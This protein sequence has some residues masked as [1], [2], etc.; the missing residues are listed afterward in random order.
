[1]CQYFK[2]SFITKMAQ[3]KKWDFE[4]D[5]AMEKKELL[6]NKMYLYTV[7]GTIEEVFC[8]K[9][10]VIIFIQIILCILINT[11]TLFVYVLFKY[12]QGTPVDQHTLNFHMKLLRLDPSRQVAI[13]QDLIFVQLMIF[14]LMI[15]MAMY[16]EHFK[17]SANL[18]PMVVPETK[19]M[20]LK[21]IE[22]RL[23][24]YLYDPPRLGASLRGQ[25]SQIYID[26][27]RELDK[28]LNLSS[29]TDEEREKLSAG[30]VKSDESSVS[31]GEAE[32]KEKGS[33][34]VSSSSEEV[35]QGIDS[36]EYVMS[37]GTSLEK[38]ILFTYFNKTKLSVAQII[39]SVLFSIPRVT[40]SLMIIN[41]CYSN[42]WIDPFII[43][44][45]FLYSFR[46]TKTF[47]DSSFQ[48]LFFFAVYFLVNWM[49]LRFSV[50]GQILK[51]EGVSDFLELRKTLNT[52]T[53]DGGYPFLCRYVLLL[54][55]AAYCVGFIVLIGWTYYIL[56][57]LFVLKKEDQEN[58]HTS[59]L[60]GYLVIDYKK[61]K[62]TSFGKVNFLIK[63]I[64]SRIQEA[65]AFTI[66]FV[67]IQIQGHDWFKFP[68]IFTVFL[69]VTSQNVQVLSNISDALLNRK[70]ASDARKREFLDLACMIINGLCWVNLVATSVLSRV[71]DF[72]QEDTSMGVIVILYVTA[73]I[74]DI[75]M[76]KDFDKAR[77]IIQLEEKVKSAFVGLN[78]VYSQNEKKLFSRMISFIGKHKL[79][80][81]AKN[82]VMN[83]DFEQVPL[84][85]DYNAPNVEKV[86]EA[87]YAKLLRESFKGTEF[88]KHKIV[89][90]IYTFL[91]GLINHFR[92]QDLFVL[93]RNAIKRN[94]LVLEEKKLNLKRYF[95]NDLSDLQNTLK[96]IKLFYQM[97]RER[98]PFKTQFFKEKLEEFRKAYVDEMDKKIVGKTYTEIVRDAWTKDSELKDSP[99]TMMLRKSESEIQ[100]CV[101]VLLEYLTRKTTDGKKGLVYYDHLKGT[102]R[103]K[104]PVAC[105]YAGLNIVLYDMK[106]DLL[107][108]TEGFFLF[109]PKLIFS[110]LLRTIMSKVEHSAALLIIILSTMNG[111]I[112]NMLNIGIILFLILIEETH[113]RLFWWRMVY[114]IFLLKLLLMSG[115]ES[116]PMKAFCFGTNMGYDVLQLLFVNFVI[117]EQRKLGFGETE[118]LGIEDLGSAVIRIISNKEFIPFYDR[119]TELPKQKLEMLV[120][121]ITKLCEK[122]RSS[123]FFCK[124]KNTC[125]LSVVKLYHELDKF[126]ESGLRIGALLMCRIKDD[127]Y[128]N[129]P[130]TTSQFWYRNFS[131]YTRKVGENL[132]A[133]IFFLLFIILGFVLLFFRFNDRSIEF[134]F[135]AID[136][137]GTKSKNELAYI[138]VYIT[139]IFTEKCFCS[140]STED[141]TGVK[142]SPLY[143]EIMR[144]HCESNPHMKRETSTMSER[145]KTAVKVVQNIMRLVIKGRV[146][147]KMEKNPEVYRY[148]LLILT[149][150]LVNASV[151]IIQPLVRDKQS[152]PV[153]DHAWNSFFCLPPK[154][155]NIA[156]SNACYSY[157][158]MVFSKIFYFLN[159]LYI[160]A[161]IQQ[162]RKGSI[163]KI[164]EV[165]NYKELSSLMSYYL[166]YKPPVLREVCTLIEYSCERTTLELNDWLLCE[167]LK[168][169]AIKA[170]ISHCT[171]ELKD[172]GKMVPRS[173]R[174]ALSTAVLSMLGL[175][176]ILPLLIFSKFSTG[177]STQGIVE[178]S[179]TLELRT[180]DAHLLSLYTSNMMLENRALS[181][182]RSN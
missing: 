100:T 6:H 57:K 126:K 69:L 84:Y 67:S 50:T 46:K 154:S 161:S 72:Y 24:L 102:F 109:K 155:L 118:P 169:Y 160:W 138:C 168:E 58:F 32:G 163:S 10:R 146:N 167:D 125:T 114:T 74:Q 48:N 101:S 98:D 85:E 159:I 181:K 172:S 61:W 1:V 73:T 75:F 65:Y 110:M 162:I 12:S 83:K 70:L 59:T 9:N 80:K 156:S 47:I 105:E 142:Y 173:Q 176:I 54:P 34:S 134:S 22:G 60:D 37:E 26:R 106:E 166:Y 137:G 174:V 149:W 127:I 35:E 25:L 3:P 150:I 11:Y 31:S 175:L 4:F 87:S 165:K 136:L 158:T 104:G 55:F 52:T 117:F 42:S 141:K 13:E 51:L 79:E 130:E 148:G 90:G 44:V 178:G 140:F 19:N 111:G 33:Q 151:F 113:G 96:D 115:K 5:E 170:Q 133:P 28:H 182:Y 53:P 139:I 15:D 2:L 145:F 36:V 18:V 116:T 27:L 16:L 135:G 157:Q 29:E 86:I 62:K 121:H 49:F 124:L 78:T 14:V 40:N 64:H 120:G 119:M 20:L 8:R 81:M 43:L 91:N 171:N 71:L 41:I 95:E 89:T 21:C 177:S 144:E 68:A 164:P 38:K 131:Q 92:Y 77:D 63:F 179:L 103:N 128:F 17:N 129:L 97:M 108:S 180:G 88:L 153:A 56:E 45:C 39:H 112:L 23:D 94:Q 143:V 76:S 30:D 152:K 132:Q 66:A 147:F 122:N 93:Y 99:D 82:C 107:L 123:E 7:I